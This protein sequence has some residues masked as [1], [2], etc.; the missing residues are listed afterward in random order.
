MMDKQD[1][2]TFEQLTELIGADAARQ[3]AA[4]FAGENLYIP[5]W[6]I[7]VEQHKAIR[8]EFKD[9]ATY[10]ELGIRYGYTANY[11]R[12]IIHRQYKKP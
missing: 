4:S 9:G 6:V 7:T 3:V 1:N 2:E 11:I 5:K 12:K 8:R 10:R